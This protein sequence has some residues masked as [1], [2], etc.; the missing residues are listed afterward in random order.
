MKKVIIPHLAYTIY[1]KDLRKPSKVVKDAMKDS[2]FVYKA[3]CEKGTHFSA[4]YMF[5]PIK[6]SDIPTLCHEL[7]HA[8]Q[9]ICESKGIDFIRERESIAYMYQY[10]L[11]ELLGYEYD[12]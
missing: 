7:T 5:L 8:M 10:A 3:C 11:N 6:E 1:L 4:I 12:V 9:N 2:T